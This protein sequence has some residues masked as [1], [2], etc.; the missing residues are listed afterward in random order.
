MNKWL[1][2]GLPALIV[3][4]LLTA[5]FWDYTQ[6]D[7]F[8]T[9][10]YSRNL[11]EGEGFVFNPGQRV[12]GTTTP[13]QTLLMAGVYLVTDDLLH[14]GNF[15]SAVWLVCSLGLMAALIA[16][17]APPAAYWGMVW[18]GA[19]APLVYISFGMETLLYCALLLV[20]LLAWK[21]ERAPLAMLLAGLLTWTRADG[22]VLGGVL[23]LLSL[24]G[25][26]R[27]KLAWGE[28]VRR[29]MLYALAIAPW[30]LFAWAYFGSPLP[31]TFEAKEDRFGGLRF[32]GDGLNWLDSLYGSP[33]LML[34]AAV[35]IFLG[36]RAALR[37]EKLQPLALWAGAYTFGYTVLNTTAFWYYTPLFLALLTLGGLGAG[38]FLRKS[39]S[40]LR[41]G[42]LAYAALL[43]TFGALRALSLSEAP[44][45]VNTYV[46][47]GQWIENETPEEATLLVG[48]L[49]VMGYYARRE[50]LDSP[51]LIS[52][53]MY[54]RTDAYAV[55]KYKTDYV[56][57]TGYYTWVG[58]TAQDWFRAYY[59]PAAQFSTPRDEF[60]PMTVYQ[61]RYPLTTPRELSLIEGGTAA[62]T[63]PYEI[64]AG[65]VIAENSSWR[66]WREGQAET[67]APILTQEAPFLDDQYPA[68]EAP[69]AETL[70]QQMIVHFPMG[71]SGNFIWE[72]D[73][74]PSKLRGRLTISPLS[75]EEEAL[76]TWPELVALHQASPEW[77]AG[78]ACVAHSGG[79]LRLGLI[80]EALAP[81]EKDQSVFLHLR[82]SAGRV[83]AQGDGYVR[84]GGALSS[85]WSGG[86]GVYEER[87]LLLPPDLPAGDYALWLGWY[88][89]ETG[90]RWPLARGGDEFPLGEGLRICWPGGT[91]RP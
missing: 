4:G 11:A 41:Y 48:D 26:Y 28:L 8:I 22:I 5:A 91:G 55:A 1:L 79:S 90:E 85:Q 74:Q 75:L 3:L 51:G 69:A 7:V 29:G 6:D 47:L 63:C 43:V 82:D 34:P 81:T 10:V 89:W 33:L 58:L 60:S 80:W 17:Q 24:Y 13:L 61:R 56:V 32:L 66:L 19:T 54:F 70:M 37:D 64:P 42:L 78:A 39:P 67:S 57:G 49:G 62:F 15:L 35:L 18:V 46:V 87:E 71:L 45:R 65:G 40:Q 36:A 83:W 21:H 76:A 52:P 12:Q 88:D 72:L 30:Y 2:A 50:T 44:E 53:G 68:E 31:Q 73:C 23:G 38:E 86:E 9:Y 77:E 84:G 27:G 20:A 14:A 25:F 59:R 16:H